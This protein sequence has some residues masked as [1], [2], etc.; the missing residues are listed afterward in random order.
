MLSEMANIATE[1]VRHPKQ[2]SKWS[3]HLGRYVP[4]DLDE[5]AR[6]THSSGVVSEQNSSPPPVHPQFKLIFLTAAGGTLL[7][8]S[9][10]VVLTLVA[11]RDAPPLVEKVAMG[12]FDLA[13]IGFGAIVGLLGGKALQAERSVVQRAGSRS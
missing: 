3:A 8:A 9:V 12:L 11:G 6:A 4:A 7:F 2:S 13:K 5:E 10:C 1:C